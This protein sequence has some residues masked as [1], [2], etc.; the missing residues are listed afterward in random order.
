[1]KLEAQGGIRISHH[2]SIIH[3]G[4]WGPLHSRLFECQEIGELKTY[5][6]FGGAM[7]PWNGKTEGKI[8]RKPDPEGLHRGYLLV[9]ECLPMVR[10]RSDPSPILEP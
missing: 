1:M 2:V 5:Y 8:D 9:A 7:L 4:F 6:R 3:L 10:P